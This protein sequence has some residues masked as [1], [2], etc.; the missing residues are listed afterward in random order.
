MQEE[1]GASG[2][3]RKK[4]VLKRQSDQDMLKGRRNQLKEMPVAKTGRI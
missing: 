4:N 3:A 2:H 1:P